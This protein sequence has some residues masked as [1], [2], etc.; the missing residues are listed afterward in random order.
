M[1][2]YLLLRSNK[3]SG[4]YALEQLITMGL[5]PYDL[6][7]VEGKSAAWRYPG[8]V[9]ELKPYAPVL[10]E[11]PYDRFYKKPV[12]VS[13]QA[14]TELTQEIV[15]AV[16]VRQDVKSE[17][18]A[19]T[20]SIDYGSRKYIS[21]TMPKQSMVPIENSV[22]SY[23]EESLVAAT[24]Q[25]QKQPD[26]ISDNESPSFEKSLVLEEKYSMPLDDIKQLYVENVLN[27]KSKKHSKFKV[28]GNVV[29]LVAVLAFF[30]MAVTAGF[31]LT[32]GESKIVAQKETEKQ[33]GIEQHTSFTQEPETINEN[34]S[35]ISEINKPAN[36]SVISAVENKQ[37]GVNKQTALPQTSPAEKITNI[38]NP[39]IKSTSG[40]ELSDVAETDE[41]N[42][43]ISV[44]NNTPPAGNMGDTQ[45]NHVPS[46]IETNN[47]PATPVQA[48]SNHVINSIEKSRTNPNITDAEK[49]WTKK[50]IKKLLVVDD[51]NYKMAL[52]G[53]LKQVTAS[54]TNHS[55]FKIDMVIVELD[56]L[57]GNDNTV[58]TEKLYFKNVLPDATVTL[59][60]PNSTHGNKIDYRITLISCTDLD[61]YYATAY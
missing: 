19:N 25:F 35:V 60:A 7:W 56:Y 48:E 40:P 38:E 3:E 37:S 11:Q 18:T 16:P 13:Q 8:E 27:K 1:P 23:M 50:R 44:S 58:K 12:S 34:V 22:T 57:K 54:L 49:Q 39:N 47:A 42:N 31:F 9:E 20:K 45:S 30:T 32:N 29:I 6:V 51:I 21:V 26:I 61:Y 14:G 53:G 33:P 43:A 17:N 28:P 55:K 15:K 5:K 46:T 24:S 52:L 4:P 59:P 10:E 36:T 2:G 41:V